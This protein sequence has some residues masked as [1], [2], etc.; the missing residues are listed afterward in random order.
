MPLAGRVASVE[1]GHSE[2]DYCT[3]ITSE[4]GP[5]HIYQDHLAWAI[6][7]LKF[8]DFGIRAKTRQVS[9]I[10]HFALNLYFYIVSVSHDNSPTLVIKIRHVSFPVRDQT[11]E[12][13]SY[14]LHGPTHRAGLVVLGCRTRQFRC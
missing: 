10:P 14:L 2:R 13:A 11:V 8:R 7:G 12:D 6:G 3:C 5:P 9:V 4:L 1:S